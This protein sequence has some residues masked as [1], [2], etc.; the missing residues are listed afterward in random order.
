MA[1]RDKLEE[2]IAAI[3]ENIGTRDGTSKSNAE[4]RTATSFYYCRE[5]VG[6]SEIEPRL[7]IGDI[8]KNF[9]RCRE[10]EYPLPSS[11]LNGYLRAGIGSMRN[12][13]LVIANSKFINHAPEQA[14]ILGS[15]FSCGTIWK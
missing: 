1:R 5:P 11:P 12:D 13:K 2:L 6:C 4:R 14:S 15:D 9:G 10:S 7:N 3:L 8:L